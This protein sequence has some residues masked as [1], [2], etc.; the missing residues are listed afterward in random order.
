[1]EKS[2]GEIDPLHGRMNI[3]SFSSHWQFELGWVSVSEPH[4]C[5]RIMYDSLY[6]FVIHAN[7]IVQRVLHVRQVSNQSGIGYLSFVMEYKKSTKQNR[8]SFIHLYLFLFATQ[9]HVVHTN[10][11]NVPWLTGLFLGWFVSFAANTTEAKT[12]C[13]FPSIWLFKNAMNL[14]HST[15]MWLLVRMR[16]LICALNINRSESDTLHWCWFFNWFQFVS[17]NYIFRVVVLFVIFVFV[18][19]LSPS[20]DKPWNMCFSRVYVCGCVIKVGGW[21][22]VH[23]FAYKIFATFYVNEIWFYASTNFPCAT[24]RQKHRQNEKKNLCSRCGMFHFFFS[25][26]AWRTITYNPNH[27]EKI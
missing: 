16:A 1:M 12:N 2:S 14:G 22:S 8:F 7:T 20:P 15:T 10:D 5:F 4:I 3:N 18:C 11:T 23:V 27:N 17:V 25:I 13:F 9:T 26:L 21:C 19:I 6:C 24:N